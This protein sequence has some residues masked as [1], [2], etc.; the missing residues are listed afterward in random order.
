MMS[1][2]VQAERLD[3]LT[4]EREEAQLFERTVPRWLVHRAA[5][6]EVLLTGVRPRGR[7]AY[8][9]G[10]QWARCHSYY[11]PVAGSWHDPMLFAES[12]RQAAL[13]LG[14]QALGIPMGHQFLTRT[15][16]FETTEEG[17]RLAGTPADVVIDA[18]MRDI[19]CRA[20]HVT[21]FGCDF[22]A[23]RDGTLIA[24]GSGS[25][26]CVAPAVYHRLRGGRAA[27]DPACV[28]SRA[29]APHLVGR[30]QEFDVVL[31]VRDGEAADEQSHAYLL[32]VDATHPVLF[33]HPV[34]HVPGMVVLEAARQAALAS[35]GLPRGLLVGC[36]AAFHR[37]IELDSPCLVMVTPAPPGGEPGRGEAM[38]T[39]HQQ[40][41][42]AGSCRVSL[43]DAG[44]GR[45]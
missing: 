37:Y 27:D 19:R 3:F 18:S 1:P 4:Q 11:G 20:G 21:S 33:D 5:V 9:I 45:L 43:L 36:D 24:R 13:L 8:R 39:F 31:G 41:A 17:M 29:V 32:R 7:D 38:V 26:D 34:D 30:M 6:S 2:L 12:I 15:M 44:S 10:A 35:L 42:V 28:P 16:T 25:T 14:H 40:D 23:H 22:T